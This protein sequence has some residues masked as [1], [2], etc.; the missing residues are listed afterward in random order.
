MS[1]RPQQTVAGLACQV[2]TCPSRP[3]LCSLNSFGQG[4]TLDICS[5]P[6]LYSVISLVDLWWE[7]WF[8]RE[9]SSCTSKSA[10]LRFAH[11]HV[12]RPWKARKFFSRWTLVRGSTCTRDENLLCVYSVGSKHVDHVSNIIVSVAAGLWL[13]ALTV[14]EVPYAFVMTLFVQVVSQ[15]RD[16]YPINSG[17]PHAHSGTEGA[18][19]GKV[20]IRLSPSSAPLLFRLCFLTSTISFHSIH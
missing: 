11:L 16:R 14:Q 7:I 13:E 4:R 20:Q 9:N 8:V 18:R 6:L 15:R 5:T 2:T 17:T 19:T 1:N 12:E 3:L 10:E